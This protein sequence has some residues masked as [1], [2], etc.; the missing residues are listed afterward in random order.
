MLFDSLRPL[1]KLDD[2]SRFL[3]ECGG[4]LHDI[5]WK[6]G[7]KGHPQ[8]SAEMI[9]SDEGLPFDLYE[10]GTI[11]LIA[12]WHRGPVQLASS[13]YYQV[14]S[15]DQQK[16]TLILVSL[17]RIADGLDGT[18]YNAI[19][20]V[21]CTITPQEVVCVTTASAD[22]EAEKERAFM[23]ADLFEKIFEKTIIFK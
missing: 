16:N 6:Y 13:G 7:K 5:G 22:V 3:L 9:F 20:S 11:G 4:L 15:P 14:L 19:S 23:K 2:R 1:H 21:S 12:L 10:R 18:H 17:L 8:M